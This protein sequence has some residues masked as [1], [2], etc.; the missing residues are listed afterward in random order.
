MKSAVFG[1][2]LL[3]LISA[4][5]TSN[6][7]DPATEPQPIEI[8]NNRLGSVKNRLNALEKL[9]AEPD[10]KIVWELTQIVRD[11]DDSIVVRGQVIEFLISLKDP[12][13]MIELKNL[14]NE[15]TVTPDTKKFVLYALWRKEP[16][17]AMPLLMSIVQN[18]RES[19]EVRTAAL[20]YLGQVHEDFPP[21]FWKTL[22]KGKEHPAAIRITAMNGMETQG[23]FE[24]EKPFISQ[25]LQDPNE[26]PE[27]RK[28]I[29][30][31]LG[32]VSLLSEFQTEMIGIISKPN[33]SSEIKHFALDNLGN[34]AD[35]SLLPLLEPLLAREKDSEMRRKL[36]ALIEKLS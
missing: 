9:G 10:A 15:S 5:V 8:L 13:A 29:I 11:P 22:F 35:P 23:L 26:S 34:F 36:S 30:L 3:L 20:S 1:V 31:T 24:T 27:L 2:A 6:A 7:A 16:K 21:H 12:W 33:N 18:S 19:T 14:L 17:T 28:S 32:R 4:P 25:V